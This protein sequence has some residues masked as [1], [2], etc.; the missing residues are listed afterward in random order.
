MSMGA[1]SKSWIGSVMKM[2]P[3]LIPPFFG[4]V[5]VVGMV[6]GVCR[7]NNLDSPTKDSRGVRKRE[8]WLNER[9]RGKFEYKVRY[10]R[11]RKEWGGMITFKYYI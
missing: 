11:E 1:T 5:V 3:T 2:M 6:F 4:A 8:F 10:V 9:E 7:K